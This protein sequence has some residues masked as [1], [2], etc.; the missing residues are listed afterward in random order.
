MELPAEIFEAPIDVDLMHQAY[1]RQMA[2]ARLGTHETKTRVEVA[3]GGKKPWTQKGTGR[4]RSGFNTFSELEGWRQRSTHPIRM[5][6]HPGNAPEDAPSCIALGS[7]CQS[8]RCRHCLVDEL[9]L[10]EPKTR[11][12]AKALDG[13]GWDEQRID[14]H[15]R[16][17]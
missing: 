9:K 1:P 4:A 3:G 2:N 8:R 5:V 6:I 14:P 15:P 17:K 11:L 16:K 7:F 12:M 13:L 10:S